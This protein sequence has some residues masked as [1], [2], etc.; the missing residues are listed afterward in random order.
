MKSKIT[1][2]FCLLITISVAKIS[3]QTISTF[4]ELALTPNSYWNGLI[5]PLG[6]SFYSGNATFTNYYDTS[7]GG[8]WSSGF[9]YSNV[10]DTNTA[11]MG[12]MY[13]SMAGSGY[14]GSSNYIVGEIDAFRQVNPKIVLNSIAQ[15]KMVD[16]AFFTNSTYSAISMRDGDLYG[17]KFGGTTGNDPDWFKLTI[18]KWFNGALGNDSV[19][20]YLADFRSSN[21]SEDY[22]VKDWR[23]VDLRTLGNVDSLTFS[24]SSSDVGTFGINTPLFFCIDHF[25]TLD[26]G[27]H[28]SE[29]QASKI[30]IYPNP[31][32]EILNI[33]S[34][35][36]GEKELEIYDNMGQLTTKSNFTSTSFQINVSNLISGIYHIRIQENGQ[37][38]NQTFIKQ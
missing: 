17:K 12:N 29:N 1:L 18:K 38:I 8:Y 5:E 32:T 25:T 35:S 26:Q 22:I 34:T 36:T 19:E 30:N 2:L 16:G 37:F 33:K 13:A 3:S 27:V 7:Y 31:T 9:A 14:N 23:W 11:G 4:E 24:M 20:F 6:S 15:G 28:I 10:H 21:N